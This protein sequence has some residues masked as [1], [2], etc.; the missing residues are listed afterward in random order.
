MRL[1]QHRFTAPAGEAD[2]ELSG[3]PD[4][5]PSYEFQELRPGACPGLNR[6]H[7]FNYAA[8]LS[9]GASAGDIPQISEGAQRLARGLAA[10]LL[11]EDVAQHFDALQRYAEPE[12]RGDEWTPADFPSYE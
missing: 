10:Q 3:S 6:V 11:A 12:L 2:A 7:C 1:W 5:G 8:A 9:L 4:L